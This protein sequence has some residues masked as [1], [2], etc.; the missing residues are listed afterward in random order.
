MN[1]NIL[2]IG[3]SGFV[4]QNLLQYLKFSKGCSLRDKDWRS[5]IDEFEILVNLVGKAHDHKGQA[6]EQDYFFVNVELV[7]E[8]FYAFIQSTATVLL[9]VSS[10]A[11]LEEYS[12]E[13]MLTESD[14]CHPESWYGRS[15]REAEEWLLAQELPS[16]KKLIIIR[17]PMIHGPGDKGNLGL[18]Y[19]LI[20]RG[21]PYP[22]ASF[23]NYRS[24]IS[25]ENFCFFI[26]QMIEKKDKLSSG[27]FHVADNESV[28]THQIIEIIKQV[29][30]RRVANLALPKSLVIG[31]A[32]IGDFI[33][34]ILNSKRLKKMTSNLLV[35]NEKSK[36]FLNVTKLPLTAEEGLRKTIESFQ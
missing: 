35:S 16:S 32:K 9:H 19:G 7:K 3:A 14:T 10:I 6:S 25:I 20:S 34:I 33:P 24:F 2:I 5:K 26:R 17:P 36:S 18:L 12:A 13:G 23:D 11:A 8:I 30:G 4:G 31:I 22:L 28:S 29:T 21:I 1:S 27:I 15:K